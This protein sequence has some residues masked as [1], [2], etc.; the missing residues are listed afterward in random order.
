MRLELRLDGERRASPYRTARRSPCSVAVAV[1][2][3]S[4]EAVNPHTLSRRAP[5][6]ARTRHRR[7]GYR[8]ITPDRETVPLRRGR[9]AESAIWSDQAVTVADLTND[10]LGGSGSAV[11]GEEIPDHRAALIL[12]DSGDH[13]RTVVEP[14]V[15]HDVPERPHRTSFRIPGPEHQPVYPRQHEG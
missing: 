4:T 11:A 7:R 1:G 8:I 12:Q 14:P 10:A 13:L 3:E 15:A 5:S 9:R 2:F 6:A